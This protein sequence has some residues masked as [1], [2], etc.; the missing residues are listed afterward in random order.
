[1]A[2]IEIIIPGR[3]GDIEAEYRD[4]VGAEIPQLTGYQ[5]RLFDKGCLHG[6]LYIGSWDETACSASTEVMGEVVT[7]TCPGASC[8]ALVEMLAVA[9]GERI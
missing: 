1:M 9:A 8:K 2:G 6:E 7:V 5:T 3:V 4:L